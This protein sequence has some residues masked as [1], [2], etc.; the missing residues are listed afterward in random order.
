MEFHQLK[1]LKKQEYGRR[2]MEI[3]S[4]FISTD[5]TPETVM[6]IFKNFII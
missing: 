4:M 3:G 6:S 1:P 5:Q 2:K